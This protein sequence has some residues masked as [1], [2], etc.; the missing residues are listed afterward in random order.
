MNWMGLVLG[1]FLIACSMLYHWGRSFR[2]GRGGELITPETHPGA[3][4]TTI[5]GVA[6]V[7]LAII[8]ATFISFFRGLRRETSSESWLLSHLVM[9]LLSNTHTWFGRVVVGLLAVIA[10]TCTIM[11]GLAISA[12]CATLGEDFGGFCFLALIIAIALG[13]SLYAWWI[14]FMQFKSPK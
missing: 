4:W 11:M 5:I 14:F 12:N 13:A 1:V 2:L 3:Y 9:P 10:S 8:V 6:L 7:G